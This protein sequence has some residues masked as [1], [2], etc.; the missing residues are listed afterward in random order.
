MHDT[1]SIFRYSLSQHIRIRSRWASVRI[2]IFF[3]LKQRFL[4]LFSTFWKSLVGCIWI[5][6]QPAVAKLHHGGQTWLSIAW[7]SFYSLFWLYDHFLWL[8]HGQNR[9]QHAWLCGRWS[10]LEFFRLKNNLLWI[11]CPLNDS[12]KRIRKFSFASVLVSISFLE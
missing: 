1:P 6:E 7:Y 12:S 9:F 8:F 3:F 10:F 11:F 5:S 4:S 2:G